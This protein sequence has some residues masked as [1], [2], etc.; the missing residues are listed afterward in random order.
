MDRSRNWITFFFVVGSPE[1]SVRVSSYNIRRVEVVLT[2]PPPLGP[3]WNPCYR[4]VVTT[5]TE[6]CG[7][8]LFLIYPAC[9]RIWNI[10][11]RHG[12]GKFVFHSRRYSFVLRDHRPAKLFHEKISELRCLFVLAFFSF[13]AFSSF[14]IT[15]SKTK[16]IRTIPFRQLLISHRKPAVEFT[17]TTTG[18]RVTIMCTGSKTLTRAT[19]KNL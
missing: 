16:K 4:H 2:A 7:L 18:C 12:V 8:P 14:L 1:T 6:E 15:I 9:K 19:V 13:R 10:Y 17:S 11:D 5:L 3:E